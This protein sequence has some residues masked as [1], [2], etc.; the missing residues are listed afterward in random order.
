MNILETER[1]ILRELNLDDA[2]FI[3]ELL[4]DPSFIQF[5]GDKGVKCVGEASQYILTGP[6]ESYQQH[7]YGLYLVELKTIGESIGI[8][9]LVKRSSLPDADIG[10]AFLP[11]YRSK[12]YA[13]EAAAAVLAYGQQ[14]LGLKRILG[15]TLPENS[16]SIKVLRK[17]GL[18]YDRMMRLINEDREVMLFTT[19]TEV[20][21]EK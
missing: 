20:P 7:G 18:R 21:Y 4:N 8:C 16:N 6:I 17:I 5:I 3:L 9:G 12:G 1:L 15:I 13:Y 10:F 19:D 11:S 14:S 2:P